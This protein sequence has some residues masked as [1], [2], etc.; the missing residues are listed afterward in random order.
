MNTQNTFIS[1]EYLPQIIEYSKTNRRRYHK[2]EHKI[3]DMINTD[4]Q[5]NVRMFD[6]EFDIFLPKYNILIEFN[7]I[8]WHSIEFGCKKETHREKS[9]LCRE[10]NIRLIHIYEFENIEEQVEKINQ[11]L[12]G[13]DTFNTF[14]KNNFLDIP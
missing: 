9:I 5:V 7:G 12:K 14:D 8:H 2:T 1:N 4:T 11:L 13:I 10:H 3:T 6:K